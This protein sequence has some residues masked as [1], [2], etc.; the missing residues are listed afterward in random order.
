MSEDQILTHTAIIPLTKPTKSHVINQI[1][2]GKLVW[3]VNEITVFY[4]G[5]C[6]CHSIPKQ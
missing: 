3:Y 1:M 5:G 2:N 6:Y 4:N